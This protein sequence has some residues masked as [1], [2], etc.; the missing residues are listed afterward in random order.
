MSKALSL[1]PST[2]KKR[3]ILFT[4]GYL[5]YEFMKNCMAQDET[6]L[7]RIDDR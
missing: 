5:I 7:G 3:S 4:V 1:I 2:A 6:L